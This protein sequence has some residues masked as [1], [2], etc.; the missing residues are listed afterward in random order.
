[1]ISLLLCVA[2]LALWLQSHRL[3]ITRVRS[4]YTERE[5]DWLPH[6]DSISLQPGGVMFEHLTA[7]PQSKSDLFP[8]PNGEHR[9]LVRDAP[10][11]GIVWHLNRPGPSWDW[12]LNRN[13]VTRE[14][15][16]FA[17]T[18][19]SGGHIRQTLVPLYP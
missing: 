14:H 5:L 9:L 6:Y 16:R 13:Y 18:S 15:L 3:G 11:T 8:G 17:T 1:M 19:S 2:T 12:A 4:S 7:S 10:S